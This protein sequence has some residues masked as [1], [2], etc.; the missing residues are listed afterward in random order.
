[1]L[2]HCQGRGRILFRKKFIQAELGQ[3]SHFDDYLICTEDTGGLN[4]VAGMST[5]KEVD[6][7]EFKSL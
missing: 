4:S 6:G 1:M 7:Q 2:P 5:N 3:T